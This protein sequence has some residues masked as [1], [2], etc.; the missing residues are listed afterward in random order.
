MKY[1]KKCLYP[2][3]KPQ[4]VFNENGV[5][6]A[7]SN[8]DLKEKINLLAILFGGFVVSQAFTYLDNTISMS[9]LVAYAVLTLGSFF[10]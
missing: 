9:M 5:C 8:S 10:M 3:T 6:S 2:D 4:L 1:C 7:C